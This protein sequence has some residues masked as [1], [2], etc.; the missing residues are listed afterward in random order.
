MCFRYL[1]RDK[2]STEDRERTHIFSSFFY[3]RL[4]QRIR[5]AAIDDD[6]SLS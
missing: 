4:T 1:L 2:L 5:G 6:P 3:K